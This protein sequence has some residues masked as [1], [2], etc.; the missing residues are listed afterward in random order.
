MYNKTS[1]IAKWTREIVGRNYDPKDTFTGKLKTFDDAVDEAAAWYI[2]NTYPTYS[3]VPEFIQ[4]LRKLPFGNFVSFPAEM[5]RT[6]TN[7]VSIGLKEATSSDPKLRQMGLRRLLGAYV[8]LT[9]TGQAVGKISNTLTGVTMEQ[10]EAYKRSLAAPWNSRA[11][12]LPINKWKDGV[13]KAIN[14]SYF[15]PYEVIT[16]PI[17][18][19]FKQWQ[20]GTIRGDGIGKQL[21]KQLFGQDGPIRTILSPFISQP[22]ALERFTDVLPAEIGLGNRGGVTK[23]GSKVYVDT[24]SDGD[25]VAKSFVHIL[26][27]IEPGAVTTG[28][29]LVQGLQQDIAKGGRPVN[30]QDEILALLSGIRIIN[31]DVPK[32]MEYKITDY[33]KK[34][35]SVTATE[36]FFSLQDFRQRGPDVLAEE[37]RKIQEEK[38]RVNQDFHQILKDA[39]IMGVDARTLKKIMR[40]RNISARDANFLLKGKNIPYTGYET[41]MK[42]RVKEA[43]KVAE[44]RGIEIN[45]EY[46]YP[47]RL[48]KDIIRQY[49]KIPLMRETETEEETTEPNIIERGLDR[50]KDLFSEAPIQTPPLG[51]TPM[52]NNRLFATAPVNTNLTRTESALLSDPLER[53]IARRT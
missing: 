16:K 2:R 49:K 43:E 27:G 3:K 34:A 40:K 10:L 46:F 15:S 45:K 19:A 44:D 50:V 11:T 9:G 4:S 38:L 32:T 18:A 8:T 22:I 51:P 29:K 6:T 17:E 35:R 12:I 39:Q 7:I 48:F 14:F 21:F 1:D 24:D 28:R 47:K 53:E 26:K 25:K 52:P 33:N 30:L 5:I 20:E 13:G 36:K 41:R 37:F 42:K 23:T 31:V